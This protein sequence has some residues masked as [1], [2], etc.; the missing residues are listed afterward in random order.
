MPDVVEDADIEKRART[1]VQSV[2]DGEQEKAVESLV[3]LVKNTVGRQV[4]EPQPTL[5]PE[6]ITALVDQ[7]SR[8]MEA[9]TVEGRLKSS[10]NYDD[11]FSDD[12]AYSLAIENVR[13]LNTL[14]Y[15]G[16]TE[17]LMVEAME[18][19]RDWRSGFDRETRLERERAKLQ[20][21][22]KPKPEPAPEISEPQRLEKKR[23]N[24]RP[25]KSSTTI[26]RQVQKQVE[27]EQSEL[28]KRRFDF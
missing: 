4:V 24:A 28:E 7:R 2:E 3:A 12:I 22:P 5:T 9:T 8:A 21:E 17:Q 6:Q 13:H 14:G 18:R 25:V 20:P 23:Q 1:I 11:I 10:G 19:V 26:Q 15:D 16:T 27:P